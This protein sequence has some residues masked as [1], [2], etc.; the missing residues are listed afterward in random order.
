MFVAMPLRFLNMFFADHRAAR[1]MKPRAV[2][3]ARLKGLQLLAG[4]NV[5]VNIDNHDEILSALIGLLPIRH[6]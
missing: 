6:R 2:D 3:Q 5:I 1:P 4:N